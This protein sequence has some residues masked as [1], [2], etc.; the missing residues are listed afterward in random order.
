[1][2]KMLA[3]LALLALPTSASADTFDVYG[4]WLTQ[5]KDAHIEVT[6][7]GDGTPCGALVWVDPISTESQHDIRNADNEQRGRPLIGVPI[8]WGYARG[9]K[10]WRSGHIYNPEYGKTYASSMRLQ[11]DGT[12]KVKGCLGPICITNI[13]TPAQMRVEEQ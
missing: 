12:L 13:W 11:K 5:A 1:M 7:C 10:G 2:R 8:V 9:L 6:D 3:S 4:L